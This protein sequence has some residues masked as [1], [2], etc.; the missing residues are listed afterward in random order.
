MLRLRV[1]EEPESLLDSLGIKCIRHA[2]YTHAYDEILRSIRWALRDRC[3]TV[4]AGPS[5][6]GKSDLM[7][8]IAKVLLDRY[9][10]YAP[11]II[12]DPTPETGHNAFSMNGFLAAM[13][14]LL[15]DPAPYRHD[16]THLPVGFPKGNTKTGAAM[17]FALAQKL[18]RLRPIALLLD[19]ASYL[20]M[21]SPRE[22]LANMRD[23]TWLAAHTG[24]PIVLFG[25]YEALK[26]LSVAEDVNARIRKAHL[27]RYRDTK[28]GRARFKNALELLHGELVSMGLADTTFTLQSEPR[29][30]YNATSGRF[31]LV[32]KLVD[33]AC[34]IAR[35]Q[36]RPL[37]LAD[38]RAAYPHLVAD[39]LA[40][41]GAVLKGEREYR[42]LERGLSAAK[43][44]SEP[45]ATPIARK[46]RSSRRVGERKP[47]HDAALGAWPNRRRHG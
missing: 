42:L 31:G 34:D 28:V 8:E 39:P 16:H 11:P 23:L 24:V 33:L 13:L 43:P 5:R 37:R 46:H 25:T 15:G 41:D 40:F 1:P 6:A 36:S 7:E 47:G 14:Q 27:P 44:E 35:E 9:P 26:L 20:A 22:Q 18:L 2:H 10:E 19:E 21:G 45:T 17:L 38:L 4:V 12:A 30:I 32:F 3:L 29:L